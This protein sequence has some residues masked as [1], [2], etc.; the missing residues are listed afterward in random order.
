MWDPGIL[1]I[2]FLIS[3]TV[4]YRCFMHVNQNTHLKAIWRL[5]WKVPKFIAPSYAFLGILG[6]LKSETRTKVKKYH[7]YTN[8]S[9][10]LMKSM[11]VWICLEHRSIY[12]WEDVMCNTLFKDVGNRNRVFILAMNHTGYSAP[13]H[14]SEETKEARQRRLVCRQIYSDAYRQLQRLYRTT[15]N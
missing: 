9:W 15:S 1:Y 5:S 12:P 6:G 14:I 3:D 2:A 10:K 7:N 8:D 4:F 11:C 13:A